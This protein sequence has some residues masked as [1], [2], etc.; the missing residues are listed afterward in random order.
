MVDPNFDIVKQWCEKYRTLANYIPNEETFMQY[1][2]EWKDSKLNLPTIDAFVN[3]LNLTWEPDLGYVII[4][5]NG[6]IKFLRELSPFFLSGRLIFMLTKLQLLPSNIISIKEESKLASILKQITVE[7]HISKLIFDIFPVAVLN[8]PYL[9][10]RPK[11]LPT[12]KRLLTP[13]TKSIVETAIATLEKKYPGQATVNGIFSRISLDSTIDPI[14]RV[15]ESYI[16]S[17]GCYRLINRF[18]KVSSCRLRNRTCE[19]SVKNI[20]NCD[21]N[22][23]DGCSNMYEFLI[24]VVL[25]DDPA[26]KITLELLNA[27]LTSKNLPPVLDLGDVANILGFA[28]DDRYTTIYDFQADFYKN[29]PEP[30]DCCDRLNVG[31]YAC[32]PTLPA[33]Y[34]DAAMEL[35][36]INMAI[37]PLNQFEYIIYTL[38]DI[39]YGTGVDFINILTLFD[40]PCLEKEDSCDN[41]G[42][43]GGD[44]LVDKLEE[45][46]KTNYWLIIALIVAIIIVIAFIILS[47]VQSSNYK[48]IIRNIKNT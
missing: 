10:F 29:Y 41:G 16:Q 21:P 24:Y 19:T 2:K 48:K 7:Y 28:I 3:N 5:I 23:P 40:K 27:S 47:L 25:S 35:L 32:D 34:P 12:F 39:S 13:I 38:V 9:A 33:R 44:N 31:T 30:W 36:P 46:K 4:D 18:G 11:D 8:F 22:E 37:H 17:T 1:F 43:G 26:A 20:N 15:Y 6:S 45:E 14:D 42:G